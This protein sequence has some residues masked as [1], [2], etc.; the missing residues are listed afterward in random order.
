MTILV[1]LWS[2]GVNPRGSSPL[3]WGWLCGITVGSVVSPRVEPGD[4]GTVGG[5]VTLPLLPVRGERRREQGA[6]LSLPRLSCSSPIA[7]ETGQ[8][9]GTDVL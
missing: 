8:E 6:V 5:G 3:G 2:H 4:R 7:E 1:A 9:G